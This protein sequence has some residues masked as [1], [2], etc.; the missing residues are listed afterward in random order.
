MIPVILRVRK[1]GQR[2]D[3]TSTWKSFSS[4]KRLNRSR[5]LPG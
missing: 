4:G 2:G 3:A 1:M 5:I